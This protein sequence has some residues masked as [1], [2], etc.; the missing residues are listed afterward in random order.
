MAKSADPDQWKSQLIWTYTVCKGRV[1]PGSEEIE[2]ISLLLLQSP[3]Y[4]YQAFPVYE[5]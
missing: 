3:P 5:S 4:N 1:Y 2:L